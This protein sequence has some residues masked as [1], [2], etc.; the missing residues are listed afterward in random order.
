MQEQLPPAPDPPGLGQQFL[1][2][3]IGG[4]SLEREAIPAWAAPIKN[5][6][7]TPHILKMGESVR[8]IVE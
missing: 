7:I 8:V 2:K 4:V 5:T 3:A 1:G 6:D